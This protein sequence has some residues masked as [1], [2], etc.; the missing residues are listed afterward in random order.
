[1][2]VNLKTMPCGQL[3]E[4]ANGCYVWKIV[5]THGTRNAN[6]LNVVPEEVICTEV[7]TMQND[8]KL[9]VVWSG[10]LTTNPGV[11]NEQCLD[12]NGCF[13]IFSHDYD[14]HKDFALEHELTLAPIDI[15]IQAL[16][17]E[18]QVLKYT[19]EQLKQQQR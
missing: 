13:S 4:F 1:M 2:E 14:T 8:G 9:G 11:Y 6:Y 12:A 3:Y 5:R 17:L 7:F 19:S 15:Q 16:E 18:V 10:K